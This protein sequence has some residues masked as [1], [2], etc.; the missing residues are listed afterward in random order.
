MSAP[1]TVAPAPLVGFSD[2]SPNKFRL[3]TLVSQRAKQLQNGARPRV[4]TGGHKFAHVALREV[5]AGL[6]SWSLLEK[7]A[8]EP[9]VRR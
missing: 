9:V 5:M 2:D 4:E 3:V 6:I 1:A 7:V 8:E